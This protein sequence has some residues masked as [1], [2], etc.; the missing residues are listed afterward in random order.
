MALLLRPLKPA[1]VATGPSA[2]RVLLYIAQ[3]GAAIGILVLL[4]AW[5]HQVDS[6][7]AEDDARFA[8][9][10]EQGRL[11]GRQE[12]AGSAG[13]AWSQGYRAG[14]VE[15]AREATATALRAGC[16]KAVRLSKVSPL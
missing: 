6:V 1:R 10:F 2:A 3:A 4:L 11:Q 16:D 9:A 15:G 13:A 8:A 5:G 12:T 7:A 14:R